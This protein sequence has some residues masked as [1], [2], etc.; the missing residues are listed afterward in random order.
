MKQ[1]N[2]LKNFKFN[3]K[4]L[5]P[6]KPPMSKREHL[7]LDSLAAQRGEGPEAWSVELVGFCT[8]ISD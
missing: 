7:A 2:K 8:R 3:F 1:S 5:H 6:Q 4:F